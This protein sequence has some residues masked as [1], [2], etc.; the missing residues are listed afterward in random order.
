MLHRRVPFAQ[1]VVACALLSS[2]AFAQRGVP[3]NGFPSWEE[4]MVQVFA[5]RARADPT[6]EMKACTA[7]TVRPPL[8]WSYNLNRAARFHARNLQAAIAQGGSSY[9]AHDSSCHLVPNLSSIYLPTGTC[10]G[11][12]S[13]ACR[14]GMLLGPGAGT[15]TFTRIGLFGTPGSG[16]NIA[17]GYGSPL[18]VHTGW[19]NSEG[20][21]SNLLSNH[22]ALGVGHFATQSFWVQN[23]G[24]SGN[25]TGSLIAGGHFPKTPGSGNTPIEFRANYFNGGGGP[26][27]ARVNIDGECFNMTLERGS[28]T[29]GTWRYDHTLAGGGCRRYVFVFE[30]PQGNVVYLPESGSYGVGTAGGTCADWEPGTPNGCGP[31]DRVPTVA[32]AA[33]ANPSTVT[34]DRTALSVLGDDDG[35]EAALVYTWTSSGPAPVSFSPNGTNAAKQTTATFSRAG[36]YVLTAGIRDGANQ[37]TPSDVTVIVAQT[38]MR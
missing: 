10:D 12:I 16:E 30:D 24:G 7:S 20:H 3:Q 26:R 11:E 29:N 32:M 33:S 23:F 14:D 35:G 31:L 27:G 13:C 4:R 22:G 2:T 19:M 25:P 5:N 9:F 17:Y 36:T 1:L 38:P 8:V 28:Q 6:G 18:H 15:P 21:C 34:A 37:V